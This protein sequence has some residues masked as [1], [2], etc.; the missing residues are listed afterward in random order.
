MQFRN[1]LT[2]C[3]LKVEQSREKWMLK[4]VETYMY[5]MRMFEVVILVCLIRRRYDISPRML[6]G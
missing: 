3:I 2:F 5:D 1:I 6:N 4:F